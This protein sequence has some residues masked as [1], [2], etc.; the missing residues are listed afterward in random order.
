[1]PGPSG[2]EV[3]EAFSKPGDSMPIVFLTGH[4]D[5]R[6]HGEGAPFSGHIKK[7]NVQVLAEL[8]RIAEQLH[9]PSLE[10]V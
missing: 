5:I 2:L 10:S 8:A 9:T 3:Q 1:M 6:A 7:V 4:G